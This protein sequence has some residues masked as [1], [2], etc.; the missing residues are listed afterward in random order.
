MSLMVTA[1]LLFFSLGGNLYL[2]WTAA[3]FHQRYRMATERL[4]SASR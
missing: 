2:G 1:F 3:E 4:R